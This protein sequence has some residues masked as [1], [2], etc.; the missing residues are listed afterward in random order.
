M[1]AELAF[2]LG[3]IAISIYSTI[4]MSMVMLGL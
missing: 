1:S 3:M 4:T 2:D